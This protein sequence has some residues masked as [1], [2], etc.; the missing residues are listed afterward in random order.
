[1]SKNLKMAKISIIL[2]TISIVLALFSII[3]KII[4][5]SEEIK[6]LKQSN[7]EIQQ[8]CEVYRN[9]SLELEN[10]IEGIIANVIKMTSSEE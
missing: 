8:E 9:R 7:I 4:L 1:M 2:A 6:Q 10:I 5:K 3:C